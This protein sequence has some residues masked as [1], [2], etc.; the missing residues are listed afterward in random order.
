[1]SAFHTGVGPS[2][3]TG[4][5]CGIFPGVLFFEKHCNFL[6]QRRKIYLNDLPD[7][8]VSHCRVAM[9]DLVAKGDD[10]AGKRDLVSI[11]WKVLEKLS[12]R[13]ADNPKLTF[14][15]GTQHLVL[16]IGIQVLI[17]SEGADTRRGICD[18]SQKSFRVT[19]HRER[20]G[21]L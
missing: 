10:L 20:V 12:E 3:G 18:V 1:M 19:L 8:V 7:N 6:V 21:A 9:N 16:Q 2:L 15:G 17:G 11:G 14:D 13:L 5:L 4:R